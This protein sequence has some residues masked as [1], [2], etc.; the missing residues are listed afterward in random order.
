MH[1]T[2]LESGRSLLQ[3]T[4]CALLSMVA[5]GAVVGVV[6]GLTAGGRQLP[7]D[8][9]EARV[10]FLLPPDRVMAPAYQAEIFQMGRIGADLEEGMDLTRP[11]AGP[12]VRPQAWS[13]R[14][15][16]KGSGAR[17]A[18]PFGPPSRLAFDSIFSVLDVDRTVERYEWSAA[19][20]YPPE[21]AAAGA[22][23]VVRAF[24]VVDTMGAVDTSSVR[25]L[26]SDDPHF[27]AAVLSA[28]G[29]MR[30][31]PATRAG[32]PVRQQVEQQFRF[33]IRPSMEL[34]GT[35]AS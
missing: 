4:E 35:T 21:L 12:R 18:V 1:F 20:A 26:Y 11:A 17:G 27:T 7:A 23:G 2:L 6:V 16:E 34:P 19:P 3:T 9:R 32:R 15:R 30:F 5:H 29:R 13:A 33:R 22:Q 14:G 10:F 28:L 31:R 24:Y 8:E 25:V